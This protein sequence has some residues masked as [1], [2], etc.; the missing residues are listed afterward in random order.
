MRK[1]IERALRQD[2]IVEER[3]PLLDGPVAGDD[4]RCSAVALE[5]HLVE[6]A[7]LLGRESPQAEVVE[8]QQIRGEQSSDGLL[9]G[10][11]GARLVE[12]LEHAIGSEEEHVVPSAAG[13]VAEGAGQEGFPDPDGAEEDH[14]LLALE[15][16]EGEEL[17]D[18][19]A[20]EGDRGVPVEA[21]KGL[22]FLEAG[23]GEAQGQVLVIPTI[24]LVLEH[25]LE[26]VELRE[27][28]LPG[29]GDAIRERSQD[30]RELRALEDALER[31]FEFDRHGSGSPECG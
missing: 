31:W 28:R 2:R 1:A 17:L 14:V 10:V 8:E 22:L 12:P 19:V 15:E 25:E 26:E 7:R 4:G 29:V 20:V 16:A 5:D 18:T 24:D 9:G 30:A 23:A 3:D 13:G 6:I 21:L 11:V 27:L